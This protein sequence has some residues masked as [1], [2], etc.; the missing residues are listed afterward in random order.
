M[1]FAN[2]SECLRAYLNSRTDIA[3]VYLISL[4]RDFSKYCKCRKLLRMLGVQKANID[5]NAESN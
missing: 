5:T 1:L 2:F 3:Y 4:Y